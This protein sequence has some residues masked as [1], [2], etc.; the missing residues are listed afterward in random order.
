MA[1]SLKLEVDAV[2][3]RRLILLEIPQLSPIVNYNTNCTS[4]GTFCQASN[5]RTIS[6]S[7]V[8]SSY[9]L[10]LSACQPHISLVPS[11]INHKPSAH[12]HP[13]NPNNLH[14]P[15]IE[16]FAQP[17]QRLP[18]RPATQCPVRKALHLAI[19]RYS[20]EPKVPI[21]IIHPGKSTSSKRRT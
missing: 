12:P 18:F 8:W 15:K 1:H 17:A 3:L 14:Q 20:N 6:Q 11:L 13:Q 4:T 2:M 16:S 9:K 5:K 10:N 21:I 19:C 7:I